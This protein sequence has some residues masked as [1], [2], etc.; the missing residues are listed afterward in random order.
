MTVPECEIG[1]FT[2]FVKA[3]KQEW[4]E[5]RAEQLLGIKEV[6]EIKEKA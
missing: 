1:S 2:Q 6:K 3:R 5:I 4:S